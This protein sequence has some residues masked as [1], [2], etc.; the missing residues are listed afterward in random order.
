MRLPAVAS[1]ICTV[2]SFEQEARRVPSGDQA[3]SYTQSVCPV[4][5]KV[6]R[7]LRSHQESPPPATTN[8][9]A[10]SPIM[11]A[12]REILRGD[13]MGIS[14][15]FSAISVSLSGPIGSR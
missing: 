2:V 13:G 9:P 12:R 14:P 7:R 5:V 11:T 10:A 6:A 3:T 15:D 4:Y 8:P 1:Q